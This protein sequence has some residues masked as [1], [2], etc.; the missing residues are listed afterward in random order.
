MAQLPHFYFDV[1]PKNK[2]ITIVLL[3]KSEIIN[4]QEYS[5]QDNMKTVLCRD[6][7]QIVIYERQLDQ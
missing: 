4:I 5:I 7:V 1:M 3:A 6:I 2:E